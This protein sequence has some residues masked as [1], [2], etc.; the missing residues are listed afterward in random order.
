MNDLIEQVQRN[1]DIS[2]ARY[3]GAYSIC[4]LALRLR[5]LF[6]W[7]RSLP[8]WEEREASEV[9]AWIGERESLWESLAGEEYQPIVIDGIAHDPFDSAA[10]NGIL[11]SQGLFYGAGYAHS[12]K[13][14]FLLAEIDSRGKSDDVEIFRLGR[15]KARDLLTLPAFGQEGAV[16]LRREAAR[17]DLWDRMAYITPSG[18]PALGFAL[19][20]LTIP[21]EGMAAVRPHLDRIA[22]IFERM[23]V[24]H[25]I[26]EL[27]EEYFPRDIW[28][29]I[30]STYPHTAAELLARSL[31]DLLADTGAHGQL[32]HIVQERD[33]AA[34]GLY[35]AFR[36]GVPKKIFP[37]LTTAFESFLQSGRWEPLAA[38]VAA[39]YTVF[40]R[41][42]DTLRA[43]FDEARARRD[44]AWGER[45][46]EALLRE[47]SAD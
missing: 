34:L 40:R 17:M 27:R 21:Q 13:P 25:E 41:R 23:I 6:K 5:H 11:A 22:A 18:R 29:Q 16:V 39:G 28:R 33:A 30:L 31:K 7:S 19:R 4:G 44:L 14:C 42:S 37:E 24:A 8:P 1:C 36:E 10:I 26:G 20:A 15:E 12:L 47:F 43:L 38:A 3:A 46:L 9:L 32:T 2:D 35:V 45:Q